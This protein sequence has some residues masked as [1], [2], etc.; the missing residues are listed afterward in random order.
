MGVEEE[1]LLVSAGGKPMPRSKAVAAGAEGIDVELEL[2]QAQVEIN[3][4]VCQTADELRRQLSWA[5]AKLAEAAAD[6]GAR[7]VAVAVPPGG[8]AAQLITKKPRY[9]E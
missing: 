3:S 6:E 7:L 4:P 8:V 1:L 9:E 2:T 5:R